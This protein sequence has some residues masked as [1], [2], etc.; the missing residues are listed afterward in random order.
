MIQICAVNGYNEVGRNCT[1]VNVDGEVVIIDM[2]LHLENYIKYTEDDD[3]VSVSEKELVKVGAV[4]DIS[5][6]KDWKNDVKAIVIGHGHLD[7]VGAVPYVAHNF[8]APIICTPYTGAI[9]DITLKEDRIKLSNKI[10]SLSS[11]SSY[12][13]TD[14]IKV[15]FIHVTHS[16]PQTVIV[17]L[18]TKY[19]VIMYANDFKLDLAPILGKRPNFKRLQSIAGENVLALIVESTYADTYGKMPSENVAKEMLKDVMLGVDSRDGAM[20]VT[21]FSSHMARLT[22]ILEFG[23]KLNRKIVFMGR[24]LA[25]YVHAAESI[26]LV[27]F[28]KQAEILKYSKQVKR[29]LK[30]IAHEKDKYLLVVTGHQA[31]PHSVLSKIASKEHEF[32]LESNDI[33][34]F[35]CRTIP[36]PTNIANR[37]KL[38]RT[39]K[40]YNVRIFKDIHQS[41]HA[42]REDLRDLI[43]ML[44]PK[45]IIPSHGNPLHKEALAELAEGIG[46]K[47]GETVLLV[48]DGQRVII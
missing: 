38:E 5:S 29:K 25:K 24:S 27:N 34:I 23:K 44:K 14:K 8:N 17:A 2:G 32:K 37:E 31:E 47:K 3:F 15:E 19:G 11:N 46:Y 1:A 20:I 39:L 40:A 43:T 30:K 6:I 48:R 22:S 21:T 26:G 10:I 45:K 36:T 42:A 9:I 18:H 7:H 12:Q 33:V 13:I 35:S 28:S 16:I 4:P 41:G